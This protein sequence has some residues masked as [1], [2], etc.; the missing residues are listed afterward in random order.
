MYGKGRPFPL[1]RA[2]MP[3]VTEPGHPHLRLFHPRFAALTAARQQLTD[4]LS[5]EHGVRQG[6]TSPVTEEL[7]LTRP[8]EDR[9]TVDCQY[10]TLG[11]FQ[12]RI[13]GTLT[14][15]WIPNFRAFDVEFAGTMSWWD[16]WDFDPLV[17]DETAPPVQ[18]TAPG[19]GGRSED[20]E[21]GTRL[22]HHLL[23]GTPFDVVSDSVAVRQ[24]P[25]D[26]GASY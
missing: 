21:W 12:C 26:Q 16:R 13:S 22:A 1:P 24:K 3:L 2:K 6:E 4:Q 17:P 25:I 14:V 11:A 8:V 19:A 10:P 23:P 15:R 9:A 20:A 7:T 5:S 18:T